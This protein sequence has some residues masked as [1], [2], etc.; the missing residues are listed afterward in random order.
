MVKSQ[1][2]KLGTSD[3]SVSTKSKAELILKGILLHVFRQCC[4][5]HAHM[6]VEWNTKNMSESKSE[7]CSKVW[8]GFIKWKL[9]MFHIK[10]SMS[11][12]W[13]RSFGTRV[14]LN[15]THSNVQFVPRT[16]VCWWFGISHSLTQTSHLSTN[17][18]DVMSIAGCFHQ[19][20]T[21]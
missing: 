10:N 17:H 19:E 13:I 1:Q 9:V 2:W 15:L 20:D 6:F 18:Y 8:L 3:P 11:P 14:V 7:R 21:V 5:W 12:D 16:C 4:A